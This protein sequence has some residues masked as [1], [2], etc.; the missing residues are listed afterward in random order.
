[1]SVFG[2]WFQ[3]PHDTDRE[4][5]DRQATPTWLEQES[6]VAYAREYGL[7]GHRLEA[8]MHGPVYGGLTAL[9]W[10]DFATSTPSTAELPSGLELYAAP[11]GFPGRPPLESA[12]RVVHGPGRHFEMGTFS[13]RYRRIDA[14]VGGPCPIMTPY[15][16]GPLTAQ[17][18]REFG[19]L[20][21]LDIER[22][23]QQKSAPL[24]LT[25]TGIKGSSLYL[26]LSW[27]DIA[28]DYPSRA[29]VEIDGG[30]VERISG[31]MLGHFALYRLTVTQPDVEVRLGPLDTIAGI[32]L[33]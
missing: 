14:N 29:A 2:A 21:G 13:R 28:K 5:A 12:E 6:L 31:P 1:M 20:R 27:F 11:I 33:Y 24:T 26:L 15:R 10:V 30:T 17:E 22:C 3:L 8:R 19:L 9:R 32:D 18:Y 25:V 7:S 23:R 16:W 4:V